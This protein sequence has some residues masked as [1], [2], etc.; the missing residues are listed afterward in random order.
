M[1]EPASGDFGGIVSQRGKLHRGFQHIGAGLQKHPFFRRFRPGQPGPGLGNGTRLWRVFQQLTHDFLATEGIDSRVVQLY[2]QGKAFFLAFP[3]VQLEAIHEGD[4]PQRAVPFQGLFQDFGRQ[5]HQ[6]RLLAVFA[7]VHIGQVPLDAEI[8]VI[9]PVGAPQAQGDFLELLAEQGNHV[10]AAAQIR[11]KGAE[12][13]GVLQVAGVEQIHAANMHG[14]G[15]R[16][17]VQE[18]GIQFRQLTH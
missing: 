8:R 6:A 13:Q 10:Q 7:Q 16:L 2:D 17:Q 18:R 4:M 9:N 3:V 12:C 5:R 1:D 15:F 14:R 11:D